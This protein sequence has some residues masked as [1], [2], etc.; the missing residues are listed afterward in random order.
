MYVLPDPYAT[1]YT[2]ADVMTSAGELGTVIEAVTG[3]DFGTATIVTAEVS[4]VACAF[5]TAPTASADKLAYTVSGNTDVESYVYCHGEKEGKAKPA[6]ADD[7]ALR[8]L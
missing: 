8:L 4:E 5:A 1:T 6:P 3:A 2:T 7:A